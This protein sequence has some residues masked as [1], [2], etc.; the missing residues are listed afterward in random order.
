[1]LFGK[2]VNDLRGMAVAASLAEGE[3]VWSEV[4]PG[5]AS[6]EILP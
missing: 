5:G 6:G 1:M 4:V 2:K 3:E